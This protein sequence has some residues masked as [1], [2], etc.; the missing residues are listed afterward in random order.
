MHRVPIEPADGC[1]N[2]A[3]NLISSCVQTF[4]VVSSGGRKVFL[5]ICRPKYLCFGTWSTVICGM[6][7]NVK[8]Q[9]D[10]KSGHMFIKSSI[11][12]TF[13]VLF[14]LENGIRPCKLAFVKPIVLPHAY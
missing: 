5:E 1:S 6:Q 9:P 2:A 13:F 14:G 7:I 10:M 8:M 4:Q 12:V 3:T 11:M